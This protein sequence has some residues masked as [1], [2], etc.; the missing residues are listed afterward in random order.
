LKHPPLNERVK[1]NVSMARVAYTFSSLP[2][3]NFRSLRK[4]VSELGVVLVFISV[5]C[6]YVSSTLISLSQTKVHTKLRT[7]ADCLA[8]DTCVRDL[9]R[10]GTRSQVTDA[11]AR[12][13]SSRS[14]V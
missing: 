3:A 11:L 6:A 5:M 4:D 12:G 2:T 9:G 7:F 14:P 1:D 10:R 8:L 13:V